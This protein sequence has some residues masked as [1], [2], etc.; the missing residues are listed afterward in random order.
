MKGKLV[1]LAATLLAY[2]PVA[3]SQTPPTLDGNAPLPQTVQLPA[4]IRGNNGPPTQTDLLFTINDFQ[5]GKNGTLCALGTLSGGSTSLPATPV[6]I[7]VSRSGERA[8]A[9][10]CQDNQG[11]L[12]LLQQ[13]GPNASPAGAAA[14]A[15]AQ[16][17]PFQGAIG[18]AV[19]PAATC[20]ILDLVLN[21][22]HLNLLGLIVDTSRIQVTITGNTAGGLLG[23]LL[24]SL[25]GP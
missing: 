24:C 2:A 18:G 3:W 17:A 9:S 1:T 14:L 5:R 12:G 11:G 21:P 20:T 19:V 16:P 8:N 7:P 6:S 4:T 23:N 15:L 13:L 10:D 25:L 22:I